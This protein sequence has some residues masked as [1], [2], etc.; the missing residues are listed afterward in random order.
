MDS[1][2]SHLASIL[3]TEI[4]FSSMLKFVGIFAAASL[5]T[6]LLGRVVFGKRSSLNHAISSAMG[7]LFVYVVTIVVYT[8]NPSGLSRFLSPLPFVQFSENNLHILP[9]LESGI[10][11][12]CENA[13]SLVI[14]AFLVNL[15]SS[16]IPRGKSVTGWYLLR[17]L[18]V[19]LAIGLHY[20]VN[21]ASHT[22]LPGVLVAYAPIILLGILIIMLVLGA[23]N[24]LLGLV[25]TAVNPIFGCLYAFFFSN[26]LGKQL[27]KS[28]LTSALICGVFFFLERFGY[29]VICISASALL[30]YLP[31]LIVLLALWYLI[32][33]LL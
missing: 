21:W 18:S 4:D 31:L 8:F 23:L 32:G 9:F 26:L 29:T 16:I 6:G 30:S 14:L 1:P 28:V 11:A 2:L 3:P 17:F 7:I 27:S 20:C 5:I 10:P 22:F 12:I 24:I 15:L 25:L 13:L 19:I 33:H